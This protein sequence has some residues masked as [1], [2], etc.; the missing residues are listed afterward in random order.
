MLK[1]VAN[2]DDKENP[3]INP[4]IIQQQQTSQSS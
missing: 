3:G 2:M 1:E 4:N